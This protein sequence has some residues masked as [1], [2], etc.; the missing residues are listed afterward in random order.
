MS[1]RRS[2]LATAEVGGSI[3]VAGGMVG[4]TGRPLA[5]FQRFVVAEQRWETLSPLPRP[6]RAA[7]AAALGDTIYVIGG[8]TAR[9]RA[10][11]AYAYDIGTARWREIAPL[12]F[13]RF[14][15]AVV[16]WNGRIWAIG[17]YTTTELRDVLVYDPA[18]DAWAEGPPLPEALHAAGAVVFRGEIWVIGGRRAEEVLSTVWILGSES[19]EWRDGP[20]MPKPIELLGAAVAGNREIHVAWESVY[21]VYDAEAGEWRQGPSMEVTRHALS[22]FAVQGRLYAIGG[23]TTALKDSPVV[24]TRAI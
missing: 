22:L 14:N 20:E 9:G 18:A 1:S 16:A 21:Q 11:T 15:A 3:Y 24:E 12:P 10:D 17:G 13:S 2:Y 5:T 7:H 19:G 8:Q 4:E 6:I 23:C